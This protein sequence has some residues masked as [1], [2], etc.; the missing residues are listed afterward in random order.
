[1]TVTVEGAAIRIIAGIACNIILTTQTDVGAEDGVH[2]RLPIGIFHLIDK[3]TPF[4]GVADDEQ[5]CIFA[6]S[7]TVGDRQV[8]VA[9]AACPRFAVVGLGVDVVLQQLVEICS[10]HHVR[11]EQQAVLRALTVQVVV[12]PPET[13]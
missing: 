11:R 10:I 4:G 3:R 12:I 9:A 5:R 1:M 13:E 2:V 8:E 7:K 6:G